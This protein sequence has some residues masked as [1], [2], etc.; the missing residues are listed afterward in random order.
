LSTSALYSL[1]GEGY[2][3]FLGENSKISMFSPSSSYS[4]SSMVQLIYKN[5]S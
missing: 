2:H 1:V 4:V 5:G 3:H